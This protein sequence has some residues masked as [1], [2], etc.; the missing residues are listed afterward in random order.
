MCRDGYRYQIGVGPR[1]ILAVVSR[2]FLAFRS[3]L[4]SFCS[5][6]PLRGTMGHVSS[7]I[8]TRFVR[9]SMLV[10]KVFLDLRVSDCLGAV[11]RGAEVYPMVERGMTG[12]N[13]FRSRSCGLSRSTSLQ[14]LG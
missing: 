2:H 3:G 1:A 10:Y 4:S 9:E 6:N 8:L 14:M 7:N 12:A 13:G 11:A 5:I